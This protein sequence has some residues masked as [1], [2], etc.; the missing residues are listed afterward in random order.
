MTQP[1]PSPQQPISPS[2]PHSATAK[3]IQPCIAFSLLSRS[4]FAL[5]SGARED[6]RRYKSVVVNASGSVSGSRRVV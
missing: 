3:K 1:P 4:A 5:L 6:G 2:P